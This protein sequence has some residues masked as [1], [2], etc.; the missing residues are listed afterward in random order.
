ME[1]SRLFMKLLLCVP[2]IVER[3]E[4]SRVLL[5]VS[6]NCRRN[7]RKTKTWKEGITSEINTRD[8]GVNQWDEKIVEAMHWTCQIT[9]TLEMTVEKNVKNLQ[10][11]SRFNFLFLVGNVYTYSSII[12]FLSWSHLNNIIDDE[13]PC[14]RNWLSV[15]A[16][17]QQ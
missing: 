2:Q 11:I 8:L 7:W 6:T 5:W 4:D 17:K 16:M 1:D 12:Y 9:A 3:M 13:S 10:A 15:N 14:Y